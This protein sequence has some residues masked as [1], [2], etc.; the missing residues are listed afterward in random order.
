MIAGKRRK[1]AAIQLSFSPEQFH[2][3]SG[4]HKLIDLRLARE[5]RETVFYRILSGEITLADVKKSRYYGDIASRIDPLTQLESL[6]DNNDII[7]KYNENQNTRSWIEAEFLLISP[8]R[9]NKT[10][11]FLD[12][13]DTPSNPDAYFCRSFFPFEGTAYEQQQPRYTLLYKEK[14]DLSTGASTVQYNRLKP[15]PESEKE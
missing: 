15:A 13:D 5:N 2:H 1:T 10:Y 4:L 7:F 6:L 11:L 8:Y 12:Q 3:L 14:I 9:G